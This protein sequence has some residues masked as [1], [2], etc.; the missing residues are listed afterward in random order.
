MVVADET[1]VVT[2]GDVV[3]VVTVVVVVVV[4]AG[5]TVEFVVL[6]NTISITKKF[7]FHDKISINRFFYIPSSNYF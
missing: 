4:G 1:L 3:V 7:D 2:L 6:N 5:G